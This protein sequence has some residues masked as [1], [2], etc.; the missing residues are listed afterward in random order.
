MLANKSDVKG[1]WI[2]Y[3]SNLVKTYGGINMAQGIPGFQPPEELL[4]ILAEIRNEPIHQYAPGTGNLELLRCLRMRYQGRYNPDEAGFFILN[5]A[6]EA[7]SLVY[8]MLYHHLG[9]NLRPMALSPAYE[10]Y[11]YLPAIFHHQV[12]LV[13]MPEQPAMLPALLEQ[14]IREHCINLL[15]LSSP[16]NPW[17]RVIP[18]E[19]LAE[20]IRICEANRCNLILDA[21]YS[22]LYFGEKKP[23]YPLDGISEY[24]FYVNSFSKLLSVT[25]WRLGY[26]LAHHS[27]F[28]ALKG[29]HD[30]I[31]LSSP[32]PL[33]AAIAAFMQNPDHVNGYA[34]SIRGIIRQN[35]LKFSPMLQQ[36]GFYLPPH[37]GGYFIWCRCPDHIPSGTDFAVDLYNKTQTAIIPGIHFGRDWERYIRINIA[38]PAELL[39]EGFVH[40]IDAVR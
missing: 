25:G 7:I 34:A 9:S 23:D 39:T 16:G 28:D 18:K 30:Y 21:V 2:G 32:A 27:H 14:E 22:E 35:F 11:L 40:I 19:T 24:V 6:T 17:G 5:G 31:G 13:T 10:S 37:D 15:F 8:T 29:I 20:I 12:H 38:Q 36:A 1:S 26:L 3:F 33:Q 4:D